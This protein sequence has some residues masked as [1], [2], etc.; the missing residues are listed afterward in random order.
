MDIL[1]YPLCSRH[2]DR[3]ISMLLLLV[4]I[5]HSSLSAQLSPGDLSKGHTDLE[6]VNNCTRCHETGQKLNPQKCLNCHVLLAQRIKDNKGLHAQPEYR[7]CENCHVEHQGRTA[8]LIYWS[9]GQD[10]FDHA[11]T[12]YSLSGKHRGL[13]CRK[14]HVNNFIVNREIYIKNKIDLDRTFLGLNPECLVCHS[15]EHRGQFTKKCSDCHQ[16]DNWVPAS[17]FSHSRTAFPLTGQHQKIDCKKCHPL[18]TDNKSQADPNYLK[19]S[20]LAY[21]SCQN[22]HQDVH[23]NK[24]GSSCSTCHITSGWKE[25][26][27]TTFRHDRTNY[28]LRGRH[29]QLRC[30]QCHPPG[31]SHKISRYSSCTDCH[32]DYHQGQFASRNRKGACEECHTVEGFSPALFSVEAHQATSYPLQGSHLAVPC[33]LCHKKYKASNGLIT[34]Q[35]RFPSTRCESCHTDIHDKQSDLFLQRI[36]HPAESSGCP[37]C[38]TLQGW[39]EISFNHTLTL[40]PLHGKHS[41]LACNSCHKSS[42]SNDASK[43]V[44]LKNIPVSCQECHADN[45]NGQFYNE[46]TKMI[47]CEQCHSPANW[48][49]LLFNHNRDSRFRLEG[50]HQNVPC[51][52]CHPPV[53]VGEKQ[54]I[55][56]KPLETS[57][58]SC[59]DNPDG[60]R[61]KN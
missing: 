54:F 15:D 29:V 8:S 27:L 3:F 37:Y 34:T 40:F 55:R 10:Q 33:F 46:K 28:P 61:K 50:A 21:S 51:N 31:A 41:G 13:N 6:G 18:I 42:K 11:L 22:C 23:Q 2:A 7:Q 56:Y 4:L 24:F 26:T 14:C 20:S 16:Q 1:N 12:G 58:K 53:T 36:N 19:F 38:H 43:F 5:F 57:C 45:H 60:P 49:D 39:S 17:G 9:G 48:N 25:V 32:R 47:S 52:R 30:E 35:F 59:H 44:P